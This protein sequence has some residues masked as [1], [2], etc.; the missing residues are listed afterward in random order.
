MAQNLNTDLIDLL[1]SARSF[2]TNDQ[3]QALLNRVT[4]SSPDDIHDA[5]ISLYEITTELQLRVAVTADISSTEAMVDAEGNSLNGEV[6]GWLADGE[7]WWE[8][9][10]LALSSPLPRACRYEAE[11]FWVNKDGFKGNWRNE[12]LEEIDLHEFQQRSLVPAAIV[13]PVHQPFAQ[14]G[15][16]TFTPIDKSIEDLSDL[17]IQYGELLAIMAR[18]FV[19]GYTVA[20]RSA[21]RLIPSD[22]DL[23]KREVE[24]L[25][26]AAIGKTDREIA[27]IL[28][29]SPA[30]VRYHMIRA[31]ERLNSVNR[32]QA[33]FKAGQLGYLGAS[34]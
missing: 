11:P 9:K 26:W 15:V 34:A 2:S 19:C 12:Y 31:G 32:G 28:E 6:F 29:L 10:N 21:R 1:D 33:I 8:D 3:I 24:C 7:R 5:A 4:I 20:M 14:I 30:T 17:F 16:V 13:V 27:M 25:S 23:T 18:R 22:C